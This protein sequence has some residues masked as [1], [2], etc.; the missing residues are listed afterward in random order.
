M[1]YLKFN[2]DELVNLEYSLNREV[3]AT[4]R[5]GG[6]MSS[7]IICCNTRKYHGLLIVPI[8]EFNGDNHVLLSALDETVIQHEKTFNLGIH[9]YPGVYEPKGHKYIIDFEY[10]PVFTLIYRV[11]GVVLKKEAILVHNEDQV[12][13]RYTLLEAHSETRL[14][15]KPYM[16]YRNVNSLSKANMMA[17]TRYDMIDN[18]I[19]SKLYNGFP[20]LNMQMNKSNDFV[21]TPDWYYN[22]EYTEEQNRGYDFREDLFVPGYFEVPIKKGESVVFSASTS[23][24]TSSRLKVKFQKLVE[25]R[26]NR[27]CFE[28][29]LKY[30]ASQ[31]IVKKGKDTEIIA[32]YPW[33]GAWGRDTFI[34]LP[35]L[36]LSATNDLKACKDVLDTMVRTL[37]KGLFP[38]I[39]KGANAAYNSVD[40]PMWFFKALQ[41]YGAAL[42]D[43]NLLWKTYGTKI[44]NILEAYRKGINQY[45][46]M[47]DNGLIWADEPGKALTWMDAI[48]D[49]RPVTARGG[50]QVEINALW[51]NAVCYSLQLAKAAEDN[52]FVRDWEAMPDRIKESFVS[53][54]W[55]AEKGYLADFVHNEGQNLFVRPNQVIACSLEYS[56]LTDAMKQKVIK[57]VKK[58]LLTPRGLRT[59]SP[60]NP[61]YQG[62]Y[63]GD[64]ATR[65]RAYH[66][67]TV[68]PWLTGHYVEA[69]FRL[70][71]KSFIPAAKELIQGFEEDIALHGVCS[72]SEVYDGNPP[73][74]PN[75]CISQA[76]SVGE[77]LR[78][79][80]LIEKHSEMNEK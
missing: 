9:K 67:G 75:G 72:I 71:G 31:F 10:E 42:K 14:R 54:F 50:F 49:G 45:V 58:E 2:K 56:P 48:V 61:L 73:Y 34:A 20:F 62:L 41:E 60:K 23:P 57:V 68:W 63:G 74:H 3:L 55:N 37:H 76:W 43:D 13:V 69:N 12:M 21:A 39:G 27:N 24:V 19:R 65:D 44:K 46:M 47:R 28:N 29:C 7:T 26:K 80:V 17:N 8:D 40:A 79:M 15:L 6:Y 33:F 4:N 53:V 1:A 32:G 70:Y 36:T 22:V 25:E 30:T 64:Q 78:S 51:Y 35:G 16:A 11:G 18:G 66:Q 38:N 77:V 5:A 59:L 52:K